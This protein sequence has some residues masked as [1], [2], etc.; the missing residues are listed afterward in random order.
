MGNGPAESTLKTYVQQHSLTDDVVFAGMQENPYPYI[1]HASVLVLPSYQ[2]SFGLVLLEAMLLG[3]PVLT[4]DTTGGRNITQLG[5][6][7]TI[8]ENSEAGIAEGI[9]AHIA[10]RSAAHEKADIAIEYARK[11]DRNVFAQR[12]GSLLNGE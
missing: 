1:K 7:G 2:E 11:F 3:T 5:K 4:T 8:V 10:N 12:I 9:L 6:Y